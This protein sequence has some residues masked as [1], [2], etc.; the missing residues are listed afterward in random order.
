MTEFPQTRWIFPSR[1]TRLEA[2][3]SQRLHVSPILAQVLANRGITTVDEARDFLQ[4]SLSGLVDPWELPDMRKA[5]DRIREAIEKQERIVIY[6]DYDVDGITATALLLRCLRMAGAN[7]A[8]YLPERMEEGYGLNSGALHQIKG[9]GARLVVTVDCG[10]GAVKEAKLAKELGIQ[11]IITDHHE[12]G[13]DLPDAEAL[14]CPTIPGCTYP[15][16]DLAGVGI[17]FKL[18]WAIGKSF[19]RG[20]KVSEEFK[21]F[22][23]DAVGLAALGTVA[24]V[25]PIQGEN[26]IIASYGLGALM[27]SRS[28]GIMALLL[29]S[30]AAERRLDTWDISF[31]LG[32]R[33]N[34]AGRLGD[35]RR[36]VELLTA[37]DTT[38]AR[39]IAEMLDRENND[40]RAI[41][42]AIFQQACEKIVR[43]VDLPSCR[44]I[45]LAERGWHAGV[46]GVVASKICEQYYRPT[47]L[48]AVD[49]DGIGHGSARSIAGFHLHEALQGF[50]D[51]LLS[52]GGHERAAG[53]KI[54]EKDIPGFARRLNDLAAETLSDEDLTPGITVDAETRLASLSSALISELERLAPHGEGNPPPTLASTGVTVA[55]RP[56]RIGRDGSHLSFHAHQGGA[57]VRAVAFGKGELAEALS[58]K[59]RQY[60]I[61]Y[62]PSMDTWGGADSIQIKIKDIRVEE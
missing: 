23:A 6:G 42:E 28:P 16:P 45:V 32:P 17:A 46:I 52:F 12:P 38:R 18:A 39:E 26:R 19:S 21:D 55:G 37:E 47:I 31:R 61:A 51:V 25:A 56:R 22:L 15:F 33:L 14:V 57:T 35:A 9:E 59:G 34:A 13:P 50:G 27:E 40:R 10:I 4:P 48:I 44:A 58:E 8:Y 29:V 62:A 43:E 60:S 36:G 30:G 24:D 7:V 3:L 41:Q 1:N 2:E 5:S 20:T 49:G 11:L 54:A 53:L